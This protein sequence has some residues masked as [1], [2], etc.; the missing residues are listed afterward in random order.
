MHGG[1]RNLFYIYK[2]LFQPFLGGNK[3]RYAGK[4]RGDV[5]AGKSV[6]NIGQFYKEITKSVD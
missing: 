5:G 3:F 4:Y 1:S 2:T 6:F